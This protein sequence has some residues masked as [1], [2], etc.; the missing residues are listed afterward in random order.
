MTQD[1]SKVGNVISTW[2][3][4]GVPTEQLGV[5]PGQ[6]APPPEQLA[7]PVVVAWR[8]SIDSQDYLFLF[9]TLI[10]SKI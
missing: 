5:P 6:L 10:F 1:I 4:P 7:P 8:S 2:E 3:Q 9:L